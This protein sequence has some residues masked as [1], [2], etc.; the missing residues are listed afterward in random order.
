MNKEGADNLTETLEK[1]FRL[2][3]FKWED[4]PGHFWLYGEFV[5]HDWVENAHFCR[6][7]KLF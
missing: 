3:E 7:L 4:N 1:S 5:T 6:S 2:R